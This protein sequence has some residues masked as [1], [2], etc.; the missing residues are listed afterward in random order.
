MSI[1]VDIYDCDI[2]LVLSI[3]VKSCHSGI[4]LVLSMS[5]EL[6]VWARGLGQVSLSPI[7]DYFSS[8]IDNHG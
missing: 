1:D 5:D 3:D 6:C 7:S 4:G 2:G 8:S